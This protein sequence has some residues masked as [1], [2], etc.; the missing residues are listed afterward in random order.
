M[1]KL[2]RVKLTTIVI[3]IAVLCGLGIW[4]HYSRPPFLILVAP[5]GEG[6]TVQFIQPEGG[7]EGTRV[8]SPIF[9]INTP[10]KQAFQAELTSAD[11]AIPGAVV[12]FSDT[13]I[14][15]GRFRIRFGDKSFDVMS[16]R[17]IVDGQDVGWQ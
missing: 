3:T 17:I 5:Y 8:V 12:E 15:P 2:S 6:A 13:T 7:L 16:S 4:M 14:L 11:V 9:T 10:V 1:S